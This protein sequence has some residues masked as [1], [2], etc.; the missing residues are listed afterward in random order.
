VGT[1]GAAHGAAAAGAG[2][3]LGR[4]AGVVELARAIRA[5]RAERSSASLAYHVLDVMASISDAAVS[6]DTVDVVSTTAPPD[7]LPEGWVP[8]APTLADLRVA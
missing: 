6:G 2:S 4:G 7:P 1:P 5:G 8:T 3:T